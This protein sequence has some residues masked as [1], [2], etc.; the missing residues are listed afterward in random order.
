MPLI[1]AKAIPRY[2]FDDSDSLYIELNGFSDV[3][4]LSLCCCSL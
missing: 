3:S 4:E 2:Y 1:Q